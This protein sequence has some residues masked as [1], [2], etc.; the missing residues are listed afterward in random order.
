M[1]LLVQLGIKIPD[2]VSGIAG[3]MVN[4]LLFQR[5]S[6]LGAVASVLAGGLTSNYMAEPL[7]KQLGM[8]IGPAGFIIG[9]TAMV[10]CQGIMAGAQKWATNAG[11]NNDAKP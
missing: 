10:I 9:L 1:E 6:P 2:I 11:K 7:A 3:G 4:A 5:T 8:S